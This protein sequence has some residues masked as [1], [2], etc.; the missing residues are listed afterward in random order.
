ME[1]V[2]YIKEGDISNITLLL[3]VVVY[4]I[5]LFISKQN[6]I[7]EKEDTSQL[8]IK[9]ITDLGTTYSAF[10]Q[11][12]FSQMI[13]EQKTLVSLAKEQNSNHSNLS[14][15]IGNTEL[16]ILREIKDNTSQILKELSDVNVS[17][18]VNRKSD[19]NLLKQDIIN[20]IGENKQNG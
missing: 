9:A 13:V 5:K 20:L 2:K 8:S 6:T 17:H 10:L 19:L 16:N 18:T 12:W 3:I 14:D 15:K 1:F 4:L 7:R 11:T